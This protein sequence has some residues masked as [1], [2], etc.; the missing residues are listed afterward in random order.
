MAAIERRREQTE[1]GVVISRDELREY[2][3]LK[4][5]RDRS[6]LSMRTRM[7]QAYRER[8]E[9]ARTVVRF[10][11]HAGVEHL[12]SFAGS[13]A[14]ELYDLANEILAEE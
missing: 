12:V 5:K 14:Q 3:N 4:A 10:F 8:T 7:N 1:N 2:E 11:H 6:E 13:S 9:F